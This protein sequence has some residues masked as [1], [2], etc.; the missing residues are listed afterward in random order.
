MSASTIPTIDLSLWRT[1]DRQGRDRL[2]T[3]VDQALERAGFLLVTG[4][5]VDPGLP[6]VIR[7][8]ARTFFHQ[9]AD[10][11]QPFLAPVSYTHVR[12]RWPPAGRKA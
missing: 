11:K 9:P 4:H 5:G 3:V 10:A 8:A 1:G 6:A 7:T 2:A 12:E